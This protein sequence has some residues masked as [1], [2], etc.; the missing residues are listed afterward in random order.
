MEEARDILVLQASYTNPVHA[1]AICH[2]LNGYAQDPM[3]GGRPLPA[4]VLLHLPEELAKR[5]HA[6]SVLAFVNGEPAGLVNCF[7]GFSTFA[8]RPLVNIHDVAVMQAF[9]GLGLSQKMLQKVED[10]ARQRGCC[11]MT[12]EV[13]EG[14]AVA[15]ASYGKFGFVAGM[16]D[17]AHGR[18]LF[19]TK[20]L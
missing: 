17:P 19:W 20:S 11:K 10:I 12:L 6:F 16:F 9:R 4:E 3:G 14:N 2:V 13:L 18:M 1:E 8:C 7:E 15:Q 5:P